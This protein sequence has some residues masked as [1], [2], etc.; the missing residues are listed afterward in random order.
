MG[1][2]Y[3]V[4]NS[5]QKVIYQ[6]ADWQFRAPPLTALLGRSGAGNKQPSAVI[7]IPR[8]ILRCNL[9]TIGA[10]VVTALETKD[11]GDLYSGLLPN[12]SILSPRRCPSKQ[13]LGFKRPA[14]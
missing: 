2:R 9:K 3:G 4:G 8:I 1:S 14:L 10:V 5:C 6:A 12:I 7:V 11:T 13:A